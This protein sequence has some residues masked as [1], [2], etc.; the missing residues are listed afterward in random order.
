METSMCF[1]SLFH[2][3]TAIMSKQELQE[4]SPPA[5]SASTPYA[6]PAYTVDDP[7]LASHQQKATPQDQGAPAPY[8]QQQ[9]LH[10]PTPV[11]TSPNQIVINT[12][13]SKWLQNSYPGILQI[14]YSIIISIRIS[15]FTV[16]EYIYRYYQLKMVGT[17]TCT[18][19]LGIW[20]NILGSNV[21]FGMRK[22]HLVCF[23]SEW[24]TDSGYT[25]G[26]R[27]Q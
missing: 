12:N 26:R 19:R 20:D 6:P 22:G 27:S 10:Q 1:L 9:F 3:P 16:S 24:P 25:A 17:S 18:Y 14:K 11:V 23:R 21:W 5:Y 7:S 8:P 4:D 2:W 15:K 13:C